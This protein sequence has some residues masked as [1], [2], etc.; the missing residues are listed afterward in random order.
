[1]SVRIILI[2]II[3][4]VIA[5]A[6]YEVRQ[7]IVKPDL[8][9]GKQRRIRALGFLFLLLSLGLWLNGTYM[10]AP[11][12]HHHNLTRAARIAAINW[13]GYWGI[14]FLTLVPIIP[15]ALLDAR[16]NL[17]RASKERRSILQEALAPGEGGSTGSAPVE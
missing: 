8:I 5:Y 9:S 11:P 4:C 17:R 2:G 13:I 15:L 1:M 12:T 16:E 6:V 10:Q 7:W 14:T 3:A